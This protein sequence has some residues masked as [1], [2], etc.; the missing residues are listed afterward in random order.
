MK[1]I[2]RNGI[3]LPDVTHCKDIIKNGSGNFLRYMLYCQATFQFKPNQSNSQKRAFTD[4][5][6]G[7]FSVSDTCRQIHTFF[8]KTFNKDYPV[9]L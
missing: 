6:Q 7:Q 9:L 4:T 8:F 5:F 1:K 3:H 2:C